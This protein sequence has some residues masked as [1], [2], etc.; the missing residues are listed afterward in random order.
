MANTG[1]LLAGSLMLALYGD[2]GVLLGYSPVEMNVTEFSIKPSS[3]S[4]VRKS[5]GVE[6]YGQAAGVV[7]MPEPSELTIKFDSVGDAQTMAMAL[8]GNN[9]IINIAAGTVSSSTPK[10][11]TLTVLDNFYELTHR[12]VSNFV[13]KSD[14]EAITYLEGTDYEVNS[15]LGMVRAL[16]GGAIEAGDTVHASYD[17]AAMSGQKIEAFTKQTIEC[18]LILNGKNLENNRTVICT[19]DK[20]QIAS[21]AALNLM[22]DKFVESSMKGNPITL[23]GKKSPFTLEYLD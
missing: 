14:D 19:M 22:S 4:I 9:L 18:K 20:V 6:N 2:N 13:L 16:S 17:Y 12:K 21:D 7:T 5:T 1:L 8:M 11:L 23:A 3:K 15:D 10:V